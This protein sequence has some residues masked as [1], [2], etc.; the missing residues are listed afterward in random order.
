[1]AVRRK[2]AIDLIDGPNRGGIADRCRHKAA[3]LQAL[4]A[5]RTHQPGHRLRA[6]PTLVVIDQFRVNAQ[7]P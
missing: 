7:A 3:R 5:R 6:D 1:M 4:Q 2:L